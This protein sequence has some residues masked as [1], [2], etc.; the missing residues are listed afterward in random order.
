MLNNFNL[1]GSDHVEDVYF[2]ENL[3]QLKVLSDPFRIK[4]LWELDESAKTGKMLAD[5][6]EL[7]P[8]K[9][10]YHLT[11]L[12]KVGLIVIERT[13][14]K[15]GIIQKFFRPIAK[16]ISLERIL[17]IINGSKSVVTNALIENA[18]FTLEKTK[19]NLRKLETIDF[20][21]NEL[22]QSYDTLLLTEEEF[23]VLK[24]R[25]NDLKSTC[26]TGDRKE[27]KK[28]QIVITAFPENQ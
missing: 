5:C 15:N 23:Q 21:P 25:L 26:Q 3:E 8:S 7:S 4:I 12:E 14:Q 22:I 2:I 6:L 13:E 17:P 1:T 28:Y 27:Q 20:N 18:L 11:E 19:I 16:Q 9:M 24:K 10:R